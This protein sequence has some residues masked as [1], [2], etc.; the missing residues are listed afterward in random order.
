MSIFASCRKISSSSMSFAKNL[1]LLLEGDRTET[2]LSPLPCQ[3]AIPYFRLLYNVLIFVHF[4]SKHNANSI[5]KICFHSYAPHPGLENGMC[6]QETPN[7][8]YQ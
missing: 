4:L 3:T 2:N 6:M 8:E 5:A 1:G 7:G